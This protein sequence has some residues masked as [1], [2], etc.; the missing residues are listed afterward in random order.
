MPRINDVQAHLYFGCSEPDLDHDAWDN[1]FANLA[2][3][4]KCTAGEDLY[5]KDRA[6]ADEGCQITAPVAR[7]E[8]IAAAIKAFDGPVYCKVNPCS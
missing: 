6:E 5:S 8:K 1:V 2:A 3:H 7:I 4:M